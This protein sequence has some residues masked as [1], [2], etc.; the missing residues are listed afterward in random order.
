MRKMD[1][2]RLGEDP[3]GGLLGLK[4]SDPQ[5]EFRQYAKKNYILDKEPTVLE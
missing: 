1:Q 3:G 4:Q 5:M 2:M